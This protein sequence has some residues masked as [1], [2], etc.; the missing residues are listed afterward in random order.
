MQANGS[1]HGCIVA[2]TGVSRENE[3]RTDQSKFTTVD[4]LRGGQTSLL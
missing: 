1:G 3:D 4:T 2:R